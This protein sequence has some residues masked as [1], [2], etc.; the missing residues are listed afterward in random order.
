[1]NLTD[2]E[3]RLLEDIFSEVDDDL[4]HYEDGGF[5]WD[6]VDVELY[7]EMRAKHRAEARKRKFWWAK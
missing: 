7:E 3:I 6:S 5:G 1:M 4:R 2:S